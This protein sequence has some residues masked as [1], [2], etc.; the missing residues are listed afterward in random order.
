M[1]TVIKKIVCLGLMS[2]L[3]ISFKKDLLNP[4]PQ[5]SITDPTAFDTPARVGNMAT[6]L[7][8]A[9]KNG[10]FYGGRYSVFGEIRG[11]DYI[12]EASNVVTG[13]DVWLQN[14]AGTSTNSVKN[15]WEI[16]RA[17]V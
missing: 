16:G 17:H 13:T 11:E 9:L 8:A 6:S 3:A 14:P 10:N 1:N 5:T 12:N 2:T 15:F 7:Y 4:I